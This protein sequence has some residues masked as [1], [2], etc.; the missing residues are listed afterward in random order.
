MQVQGPVYQ[1]RIPPEEEKN[2]PLLRHL[3]ESDKSFMAGG[4]SALLLDSYVLT[5]SPNKA[6]H[7]SHLTRRQVSKKVR[8][9]K[10]LTSSPLGS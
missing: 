7:L 8:W 4:T 6:V 10:A 9:K 3:N 1:G 5:P 2:L